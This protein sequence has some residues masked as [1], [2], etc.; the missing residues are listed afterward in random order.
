MG[1]L[2]IS[3]LCVLHFLGCCAVLYTF[4]ND[5]P[6][7][8]KVAKFWIGITSLFPL[9]VILVHFYKILFG[10]KEPWEYDVDSWASI[11]IMSIPLSI[12]I[13]A[14]ILVSKYLKEKQVKLI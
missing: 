7:Q 6:A 11:V 9:V 13:I 1:H 4:Y 5:H 8:K 2:L 14:M 10:N 3:S 12:G